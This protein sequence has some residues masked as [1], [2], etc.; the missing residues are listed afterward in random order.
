[1]S[2]NDMLVSSWQAMLNGYVEWG[3]L[4]VSN[5]MCNGEIGFGTHWLQNPISHSTPFLS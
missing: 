5:I 2:C 4:F 1:M 3:D